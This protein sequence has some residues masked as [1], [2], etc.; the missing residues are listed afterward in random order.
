MMHMDWDE[1]D[2]MVESVDFCI[3]SYN[4][5]EDLK[6]CLAA[7]EQARTGADDR[8][9]VVDNGS[10]DG[11]CEYLRSYVHEHPFC[12]FVANNQNLG[13]AAGRNIAY[14]LS[15][16]DI[17]ISLDDDSA[18][19]ADIVARTREA[20]RRLPDAGVVAYR[21]VHPRTGEV[22]NECGPRVLE[23]SCFHGAG[24]AVHRRAILTA[25]LLDEE[26]RFGAEELDYSI[27]IR[28]AG[29]SVVYVPDIVVFHNSRIRTGKHARDTAAMWCYNFARIFFKY[30][31]VRVAL[32][33]IASSY[34]KTI[35]FGWR[36]GLTLWIRA[37]MG[38]YV[39]AAAG[40]NH[41]APL[42]A[43]VVR[44][45]TSPS[46]VPAFLKIGWRT[47]LVQQLSMLFARRRPAEK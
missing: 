7:A 8:V 47:R 36:H 15:T 46:T 4:R 6:A 40:L 29:S 33:L 30:F 38:L 16:S 35:G 24:Y 9:I 45:Y 27:R 32:P 41:R 43:E 22:Q 28:C 39:G 14:R 11:T 26:C 20:F 13:V 12:T 23:V 42:P 19:A 21:I 17:I 31:P 10:T 37:L 18:P 1:W 3:L 44:F 25:G 2:E 5:L 34:G